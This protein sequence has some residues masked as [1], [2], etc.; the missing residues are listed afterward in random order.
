MTY[1]RETEK[2]DTK[3][4]E[5]FNKQFNVF[6]SSW[7]LSAGLM[8]KH[9]Y[10]GIDYFLPFTDVFNHKHVAESVKGK[11]GSFNICIGITF[12]IKSAT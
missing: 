5:Q 9:V 12:D 4:I 3:E 6:N 8:F 11:I 10:L 7:M 1:D 2:I